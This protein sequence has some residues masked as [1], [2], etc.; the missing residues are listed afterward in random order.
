MTPEWR[1]LANSISVYILRRRLRD[2]DAYIE[3]NKKRYNIYNQ[4]IRETGTVISD[5]DLSLWCLDYIQ[6]VSNLSLDALRRA[7]EYDKLEY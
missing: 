5:T 2:E 3:D 1:A 4:F 6:T 7:V